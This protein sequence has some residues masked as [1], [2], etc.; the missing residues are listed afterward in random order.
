M[1]FQRFTAVDPNELRAKIDQAQNDLRA[2]VARN[3]DA[4][5]FG[6]AAS[7]GSMLTTARR[8]EEARDLL[9][10]YLASARQRGTTEQVGWLLL[11]LAT[12]NQYLGH[13][14]EATRQ[15]E[16]AL[17]LATSSH[18]KRLEHFTLHHWGRF[19]V[20]ER[21]I[22]RARE[23]FERALALRVELDDP[24]QASSRKA[25]EAIEVMANGNDA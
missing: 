23:C 7:L 6:V 12:T 17:D 3:D 4:E 2:A 22:G 13:R 5:A 19:L 14:D 10:G 1:H 21:E 20:E 25:L 8:E 11:F 9:A 18:T 24:R 15:F 16:E